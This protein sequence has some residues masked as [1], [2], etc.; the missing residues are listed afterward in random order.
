[1]VKFEANV[2]AAFAES[3]ALFTSSSDP[4]IT[5]PVI[6]SVAGF[7]ISIFPSPWGVINLPF[8]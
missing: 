2:K 1:M 3:T 6:S 5:K 7:T 8:M 4:E